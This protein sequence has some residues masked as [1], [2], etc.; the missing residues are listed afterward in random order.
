MSKQSRR[1]SRRDRPGRG[2]RFAAPP[3]APDLSDREERGWSGRGRAIA[4]FEGLPIEGCAEF[5]RLCC[6]R[7]MDG[8]KELPKPHKLGG[9]P[10]GT[11]YASFMFPLMHAWFERGDREKVIGW[12]IT[13]SDTLFS[14]GPLAQEQAWQ[15][16]TL[17]SIRA[18]IGE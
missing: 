15:Q 1:A 9:G 14:T 12:A 8:A 13:I 3:P 18:R 2:V 17:A 4:D 5:G 7:L 6:K 11:L 10:I 16:E